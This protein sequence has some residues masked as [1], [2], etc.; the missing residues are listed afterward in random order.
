MAT[1]EIEITA[2]YFFFLIIRI[3][4]Y[5]VVISLSNKFVLLLFL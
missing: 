2:V 1:E 5:L 4:V 3:N